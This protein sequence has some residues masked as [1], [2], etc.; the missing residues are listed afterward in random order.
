MSTSRCAYH[1]QYPIDDN[2]LARYSESHCFVNTIHVLLLVTIYD[3][4]RDYIWVNLFEIPDV[5]SNQNCMHIF[6]LKKKINQNSNDFI[7]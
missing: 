6:Q 5:Y 4:I 3:I 1:K 7:L 2:V